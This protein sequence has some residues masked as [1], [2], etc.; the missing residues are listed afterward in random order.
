MSIDPSK[1]MKEVRLQG[2]SL[3]GLSPAETNQ[4]PMSGNRPHLNMT[5]KDFTP[6]F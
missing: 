3:P 4:T 5:Q 2:E 6:V 1:T